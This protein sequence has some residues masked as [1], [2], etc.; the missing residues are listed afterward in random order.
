M[1][2]WRRSAR[3][4]AVALIWA[5]SERVWASLSVDWRFASSSAAVLPTAEFAQTSVPFSA[6]ALES[7]SAMV[8]APARAWLSVAQATT[9][10]SAPD[11]IFPAMAWPPLAAAVLLLPAPAAAY[12]SSVALASRDSVLVSRVASAFATDLAQASEPQPGLELALGMAPLCGCISFGRTR[13]D[14]RAKWRQ[15]R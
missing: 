8:S 7:V 2:V 13:P 11:L 5:E 14:S 12:L 3:A 1:S 9:L 4:L 6:E 15:L 10:F